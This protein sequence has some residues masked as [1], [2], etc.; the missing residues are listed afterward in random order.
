MFTTVHLQ[1]PPAPPPA[2]CSGVEVAGVCAEQS[3]VIIGSGAA[4]GALL[5]ICICIC[6]YARCAKRRGEAVDVALRS[7]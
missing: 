2:P 5:L 6:V 7:P 3:T 1:A 4:G